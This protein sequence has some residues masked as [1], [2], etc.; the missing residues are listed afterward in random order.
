MP[1]LAS[2]PLSYAVHLAE[3]A[4]GGESFPVWASRIS[5]VSFT[6]DEFVVLNG[7]ALALMCI[8]MA[9]ASRQPR[10]RRFV[11]TALAAIVAINGALHVVASL[12]SATYSPGVIS[13]ALVWLPL[14]VW[15]L[16]WAAQMS[17]ARQLV[18]GCVAGALVHA[19]VSAV[20]FF[21]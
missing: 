6:H 16:R 8:A 14:G 19:V 13:G 4:W 1:P 10:A 17:T 18:G 15:T 3:E 7:V 20:A 11:L 21:H 12:W 5:G 2:F 9:V